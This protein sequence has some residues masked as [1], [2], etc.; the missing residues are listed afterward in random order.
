MSAALK[1]RRRRASGGVAAPPQ[2]IT[3]DFDQVAS[4]LTNTAPA[5]PGPKTN[6]TPDFDQVVSQLVPA[7]PEQPLTGRG[8][9]GRTASQ[10][11]AGQ[12]PLARIGNAIAQG[13]Q[14]GFGSGSFGV[15]PQQTAALQNAGIEPPANGGG[16]PLQYANKTAI[17]TV[18]PWVDLVG[19]AASGAFSG[20]Q[21]GVA[22]TGAELGAPQIGRDVAALPE[23]FAGDAALVKTS[24]NTPAPPVKAPITGAVTMDRLRQAIIDSDAYRYKTMPPPYRPDAPAVAQP[25]N[26]SAAATPTALT[27]MTPRE[28]A[29][30]DAAAWQAQLTKSPTPGDNQIYV[31]GSMPTLAEVAANPD[32]S[33]EQK[34]Y[35]QNV[36][37]DEFDA[38][39]QTNNSARID[40][41]KDLA[42]NPDTVRL[43]E[44]ARDAQFDTET[45]ASF[46]NKG[47][48]DAAPI[49][50]LINQTIAGPSGKNKDVVST[51]REIQTRL[52]QN[53][54]LD[55]PLEN[56]PEMLYGVR[57]A[58]NTMLSKKGALANPQ[59]QLAAAELLEVKHALDAAIEPAAP[60][61]GQALKNYSDAT[62][63]IETQTYLQSKL[64]Q[65]IQSNGM[66]SQPKFHDM[67]K[68]IAKER[69]QPGVNPAKS[70]D[71]ATQAGLFAIHNDL[72]R[73]TNLDLG[74]ARG[75]DTSQNFGLAA[76]VAK[77]TGHVA[78]HA[79]AGSHFPLVGNAA[80]E[81]VKHVAESYSNFKTKAAEAKRVKELL[82]PKLEGGQ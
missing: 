8:A 39:K 59:A 18:V 55:A 34:H 14:Q 77:K 63:P 71:P 68:T 32:I 17:N 49:D 73:T 54:D 43:G 22:Q 48:A 61:F 38:R 9:E 40:M 4:Q 69:A 7:S 26:L 23:A 47:I 74:K 51:L 2:S 28:A 45:K 82:N 44:D 42:G 76:K 46:R 75:S 64:P 53:N 79:I 12:A 50:D 80:I 13:A 52:H 25:G 19:R 78:A 72:N 16:T 70:I 20:L 81:G 56:D 41:L 10:I 60:G 3:P 35:T 21:A 33:L 66:L 5:A 6:L 1:M 31:P 62:R 30:N 67:M 11:Q 36:A 29:A 57:K 37:P 65:V 27:A 15:S 24:D 58:I